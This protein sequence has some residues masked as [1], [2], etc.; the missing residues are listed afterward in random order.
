MLQVAVLAAIP[1][2]VYLLTSH[3]ADRT[4]AFVAAVLVILREKNGIALS[5]V[6]EVSHVKLLMSDIFAMG[7]MILS[8]WLFYRWAEKPQERRPTVVALGGAISLLSLM[9]GHPVLLI[10]LMAC[11]ILLVV[12]TPLRLRLHCAL[13]LTIG[14]VIPM[15]PWFWRNYQMTGEFTFQDPVSRYTTHMAGLYSLS[16]EAPLRLDGETDVDYYR[17]LRGQPLEFI[18]QYPGEVAKFVSAHQFHNMILSYA[19]LPH[20]FR[21]ESLRSHVKSEP[22]WSE[23]KG[24]LGAQG[25]V[26]L[27]LNTGLIALGIGSAW[28]KQRILALAPVVF[29]TGYI[30]SV[31]I[32]RLSG[33]R[34]IQPADW[35]TLVYYSIGLMQISSIARF[36][37][38][39]APQEVQLEARSEWQANPQERKWAGGV[40]AAS[41][42]LLCVALALTHGH[43]LFSSRFPSKSRDQLLEEYRQWT[44]S[45][46][47]APHHAEVAR[48][49]QTEDAVILY[50]EA[51]YPAFFE[52]D[53][54]AYNHYLLSYEAKPYSRVVFHLLGPQS[55]GV[56][57]PLISAPSSFPDGAAVIVVGCKEE[58]GVVEAV[59]TLVSDDGIVLHTSGPFAGYSCPESA[60]E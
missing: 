53:R 47:G 4:A 1:V 54:G 33:W 44:G 10:P 5:N 49:L 57:L 59:F 21:I 32:G 12:G 22:F 38:L 2:L 9:R 28:R 56:V 23:W 15:I 24:E 51:I 30:L 35:I 42:F 29:G 13:L 6:I 43:E 36:V 46:T 48:F 7:L 37:L 40:A 17:R 16:L 45:L 34:F 39:R 50:G 55:A 27:L 52:A 3:L 20:S 60:A 25:W 58:T 8:L 11:M 19:Y 18:Q 26:L 14:A 41:L 31:S